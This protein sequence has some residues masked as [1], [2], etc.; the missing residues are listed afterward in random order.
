MN[1]DFVSKEAYSRTILRTPEFDEF[2][3]SLPS[4]VQ[5]KFQ[6]VLNV[7]AKIYDVPT[8]FIKHLHD[9]DLYE[10]RVSVGYNE[11]RTLLFAV[12]HSNVI[13]STEVL[14]LNGFLKKDNKDYKKQIEKAMSI[15]NKYEL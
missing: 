12:N 10:V 7:L 4:K 1:S 5:V 6:Y 8:K 13:E 9:T 11:Y 15:L 2:Y 14:L 3:L